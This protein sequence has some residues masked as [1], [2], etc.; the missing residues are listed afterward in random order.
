MIPLEYIKQKKSIIITPSN[1]KMELLKKLS[2]EPCFYQ[3]Q[4]LTLS[5]LRNL[6]FYEYHPEALLKLCQNFNLIP[7]NGAIMLEAMYSITKAEQDSDLY[8]KKEWLKEQNLLIYHPAFIE[9]L[10]KSSVFIYGYDDYEMK[11]FLFLL[12][13]YTKV[14]Y[15][16]ERKEQY[17]PMVTEYETLEEEVV[18]VAEQI[19]YLLKEGISTNQIYIGTLNNDYRSVLSKI[20][21]QFHIPLQLDTIHSL[22]EYKM[23]QE[24]LKSIPY[25]TALKE[26]PNLIAE[27]ENKYSKAN[28]F[29]A[30]IYE[31]LISIIN[32]YYHTSRTFSEI[33]D[34]FIYELKKASVRGENYYDVIKEVDFKTTLF[35]ENDYI[36]LLGVNLG[37]FPT[38]YEDTEYF[39]DQQKRLLALSTSLEKTL[40]E[41]QK[42]M[43]KIESLPHVFL[44]YKKKSPFKEYLRATFLEHYEI[45]RG[46]YHYSNQNYNTY[47]LNAAM[48]EFINFNHKTENLICR[49]GLETIYYGNYDNQFTGIS[50]SLFEKFVPYVV[51]SYTSMQK[52][53]ECPFKYY[54]GSIL[55]IVPPFIESTSLMVGNLFHSILERYFRKEKELDTIIEEELSYIEI[56]P[57]EKRAFYFQKYEQEIRRLI[58]IM[59][60][61]LTH[62]E[63]QPTYFE[64]TM[65]WTESKNITFKIFGK[66]DKIMTVDDGQNSYV[67]VVDYKTGFATSDLSKVI[68]G[69]NMQLLLY[70]YLISKDKKFQ[71]YK[72]GGAYIESIAA[73]VPN[74]V[75]GKTLDELLWEQSKLDGISL[76]RKEFISRLDTHYEISSYIKGVRVKKDGE[77][78]AS[79]RLLEEDI[80][81]ELLKIVESNIKEVEKAVESADFKIAPKKFS[82]EFNE[83]ISSCNYCPYRD[84]CYLK[85]NNVVRLKEYKDLEFLGGEKNDTSKT[86]RNDL[87]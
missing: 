32:K 31:S 39:S 43:K 62:S 49:Y 69:M 25:G 71:N 26:F 66:I 10:K 3:V 86:C 45:K 7:D 29:Y 50:K 68:Y 24:F 33:Y 15:L 30:Q 75:E 85:P 74:Y 13:I 4:F 83:Q 52:F 51:L 28:P 81:R 9:Q 42:I 48:D 17:I 23:V 84:I 37:E 77:F 22:F 73:T 8:Q 47:L 87:D 6:L 14:E 79:N 59:D 34:I 54:I 70:L 35:H 64:E 5:E 58:Q 80:L 53:F 38:I 55:K 27:L 65:E 12:N 41:E 21:H 20:F 72:V 60:I 16:E 1:Y 36:F 61:Q 2:K 82:S 78:Y 46:E 44:S 63:F 56:V 57:K 19:S 18:G 76:K 11:P 40:G 67:I